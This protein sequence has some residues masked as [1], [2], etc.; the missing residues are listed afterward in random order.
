MAYFFPLHTCHTSY[1]NATI[2]CLLLCYSSSRQLVQV[3]D[4]I[5]WTPLWLPVFQAF[6][7]MVLVLVCWDRII[8]T[9]SHPWSDWSMFSLVCFVW[10]TDKQTVGS[11]EISVVDFPP[12]CS[13]FW[14]TDGPCFS[15]AKV[16]WP[17]TSMVRIAVW[18]WWK[19]AFV[20][21]LDCL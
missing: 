4:H 6:L 11:T 20:L 19:L 2:L 14:N 7:L 13:R 16:S 1:F 3:V 18:K 15:K 21:L 12:I 8:G 10:H 9:S 17:W 5:V